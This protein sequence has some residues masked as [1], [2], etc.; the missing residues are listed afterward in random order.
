MT[1]QE[2]P[3]HISFRFAAP[4]DVDTYFHWAND[5]LVRENSFTS[6]KIKYIDHVKWFR[7]NIL[8][9]NCRMYLFIQQDNI[10][11]GQVRIDRKKMETTVGISIDEKYR[12]KSLGL[13]MIELATDD[14]L[15][16]NPNE[17]LT[18]YIKPENTRSYSIFRKAGF[19]NEQKVIE[20]NI[21][22]IKLT[23]TYTNR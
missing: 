23:K 6:S 19:G 16:R 4:G 2:H 10:P 17:N 20:G 8:S 21:I 9:E 3:I 13:K 18:A 1:T 14:Y 5:D 12:G 15:N 11:V 7:S 22:C